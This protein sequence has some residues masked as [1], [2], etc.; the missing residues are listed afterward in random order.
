MANEVAQFETRDIVGSTS[1]F[2]GTADATGESIPSVAGNEIS[3]CIVKNVLSNPNARKLLV[4]FDGGSNFFTL[5]RSESI[6][7][8]LKGGLTQIYVKSDS[9]TV[10]YEVIMNRE[11]V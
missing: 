8:G 5:N 2:D 11:L 7:W 6:V 3:E 4:S 9:A 1:H 10:D